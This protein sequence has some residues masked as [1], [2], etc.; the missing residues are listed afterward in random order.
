MV[1]IAILE[2]MFNMKSRRIELRL[3]AVA[4]ASLPIITT[5]GIACSSTASPGGI[6]VSPAPI[7]ISTP[8]A[9]VRPTVQP[10]AVTSTPQ[11]TTIVASRSQPVATV[12]VQ[13]L[14]AL[15]DSED[16]PLLIDARIRLSYDS[17]HIPGAISLPL[18]ELEKR[19]SEIPEDRL[20]IFYCT[21]ST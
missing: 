18:D 17:G 9:Y 4:L 21:G 1:A 2:G 14:K 3:L 5:I 15:L 20:V 8:V 16:K 13:Q 10:V 11:P 6:S 7:P 19:T 12:T